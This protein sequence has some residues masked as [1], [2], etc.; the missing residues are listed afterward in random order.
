MGATQPFDAHVIVRDDLTTTRNRPS[1]ADRT[2][3]IILIY[4]IIIIIIIATVSADN[5]AHVYHTYHIYL[6]KNINHSA[7]VV[8]PAAWEQLPALTDAKIYVYKIL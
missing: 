2:R 8:T 6:Y 5:T 1:V 3:F 7:T 4:T